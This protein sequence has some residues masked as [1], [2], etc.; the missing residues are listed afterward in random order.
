[1]KRSK[2]I[3]IIGALYIIAGCLAA[4]QMLYG[5]F[6]DHLYL[7]FTV[8]MLPVGLGLLKGRASSR[9]WAKAWI[10]LFSLLCGIW[11]ILYPFL[12]DSYSVA[13]FDE[14]LVGLPRHITA[15]GLPVLFLF[16]ARWMWR[17]LS[18]PLIAPFFDDYNNQKA[19]QDGAHQPATR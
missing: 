2:S 5:L 16:A 10:R 7:N 19:E 8:L 1:M 12:G 17:R 15:V 4:C 14:Q 18:D 9:G 3:T 6:H 11:L 13:W